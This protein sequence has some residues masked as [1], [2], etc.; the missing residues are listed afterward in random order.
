MEA[1]YFICQLLASIEDKWLKAE[2]HIIT[3]KHKAV[4]FAA[5]VVAI[6]IYV[7]FIP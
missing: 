1:H 3:M 2:V 4:L 5:L 6:N 7:F